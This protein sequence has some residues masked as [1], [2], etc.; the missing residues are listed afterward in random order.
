[1]STA[2]AGPMA[3]AP[4]FSVVT[5]AFNAAATLEGCLRSVAGQRGVTVEHI[6]VDGGSNDGSRELL[7][8]WS[9]RLAHWQSRPDGGI[10]DAM[11]QGLAKARGEW[12]LFLHA[13]D[14][15]LDADV[16]AAV[17]SRLAASGA[18]IVGFPVLYGDANHRRRLHP[19]GGN[20]WLRLKTGFHHQGT[21]I[22][23][24][25]FDAIGGHDASLG[26]A[27]DYEFFLR[28]WTRGVA[29][30][31]EAEPAV[32]WM[33][34]GGVSSRRDWPTLSRRFAEERR[35]QAMHAGGP[36]ARLGYAAWWAAYLPY[37]RLRA[38]LQPQT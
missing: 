3:G 30:R 4:L 38:R 9:P 7:Q 10:A 34:D 11:N 14:E 36:L 5:A 35:I 12:L 2:D 8:Q 16:L 17:A 22:R 15:L 24:R 29:M 27:M 37:R 1:M 13:D 31:T 28:A 25:V 26:I 19:R 20:A 23:R 21:F 32:A 18:D 33:R 6:V